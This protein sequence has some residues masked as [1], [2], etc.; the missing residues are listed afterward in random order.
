MT[1]LRIAVICATFILAHTARAQNPVA[2]VFTYQG[3]FSDNGAPANGDYDLQFGLY[4]GES[5]GTQLGSLCVDNRVVNN[6]FIV[7]NLDFGSTP[8][9]G[10]ARF[11]ELR[12]RPAG[13]PGNCATGTYTI[14]MPRQRITSCI[15]AH[16]A[17]KLT[18]PYV[19]TISTPNAFQVFTTTSTPNTAAF[20]GGATSLTGATRGIVGAADSSTGTG[21]L[22]SVS[23][24][25]GI[26]Y[27]V[28]GQC[29]SDTGIGVYGYNAAT[30]G[31]HYGVSGRTDNIDG[32][33]V[34]GVSAGGTGLYGYAFNPS[35]AITGTRGLCASPTGR[36]VY[37]TCQGAG[38][39]G[40]GV[41]G[42]CAST[43]FGVYALGRVGATGLKPFRI[44]HPA[45]PESKYLF[46]YSA[47]GP[48][49]LNHYSGNITTGD[50][51]IAWVIL[52]D[53]FASINRDYR[54]QLTVVDESDEFIQAKVWRKI[55]AN[56]FAVK[57][58]KPNTQVSWRVEATRDDAWVRRYGAPVVVNKD[59]ADKGKYQHPELYDQPPEKG[60][61]YTPNP[62]PPIP[63][64]PQND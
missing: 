54:Y 14:M 23:S 40:Y 46:H 58:S 4:A 13:A 42:E 49:P 62:T 57:T 5:G 26:C 18:H 63:P 33:G 47:E 24:T 2:T 31:S 3:L 25:T 11:L 45:D 64:A 44:D 22:G 53:Y 29:G 17:N 1:A 27:G 56:R 50:D 10:E 37:G 55:N 38:A 51:S 60:Q 30:S 52:P 43:G 15:Y 59:P 20:F 8:F 7:E 36:G 48:E 35:G 19:E 9:N 32:F 16:R 61:F 39:T 28:Y 12:F 21:V 34:Y 41:L 6:G